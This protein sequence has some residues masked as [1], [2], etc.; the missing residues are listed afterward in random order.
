MKFR[1]YAFKLSLLVIL[2]FVLQII[3]PIFTDFLVLDFRAFGEYWRFLSSIFLH[4][5][6]GHLAYNLFALLLFGSVLEKVIG[7]KKFLLVFFITGIFA[8]LIAIKFYSSSLG[9]SGAIFG[10]IG[11]L[12]IV[13]PW[14]MIW[15]F[16]MPMPLFIAGI[17]WAFGDFVG[18]VSFFSGNAI[19]NTGNIAHLS[20]MF[21]GFVFGFFYRGRVIRRGKIEKREKVRFRE[22]EVRD[23]EDRYFR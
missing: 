9:A 6:L 17:L 13:R 20:G 22:R 5:G 2:F 1:F 10:I 16:V 12:I 18:A 11:A 23:W 21:L 15:A 4:G 3:F 19:D 14:F 7:G 8:N